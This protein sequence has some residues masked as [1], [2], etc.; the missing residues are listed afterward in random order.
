M[1]KQTLVAYHANCTDGLTAAANF[2][3][4]FPTRGSDVFY[5]PVKY[6]CDETLGFADPL[7]DFTAIYFVDFCP[8][9]ETL[10]KLVQGNPNRKII[11]LDHHQ[12]AKDNLSGSEIANAENLYVLIADKFSGA[13]LV[14]ALHSNLETLT[15]LTKI[16]CGHVVTGDQPYYTNFDIKGLV[17]PLKMD[18]LTCIVMA[19][20]LW[21]MGELKE[22]GLALD[23]WL[24]FHG[25]DIHHPSQLR[26]K[27]DA[28]GGLSAVLR[29]GEGIIQTVEDLC[30][31]SLKKVHQF[32]ATIGGKKIQFKIG[33]PIPNFA[34]TWS[35]IA[36]KDETV[37]TIVVGMTFDGET[38]MIELSFRCNGGVKVNKIAEHVFGGGGHPRAS[39][40]RFPGRAYH[41]E[42]IWVKMMRYILDNANEVFE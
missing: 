18:R 2:F 31:A 17:D 13:G 41:P 8:S 24:K 42:I 16:P 36:Y 40:A 11:V 12:T 14:G 10:T 29:A 20:D 28:A 34:S 21:L 22:Q 39:G 25:Q 38:D 30:R 32:N 1:K 27:I 26:E 33:V 7:D 9:I 5:T 6:G 37:P 4:Q 23:A 15:Q 3:E 35:E 19:R